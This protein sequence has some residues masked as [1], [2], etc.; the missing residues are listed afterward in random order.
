MP[1]S[2]S[3]VLNTQILISSGSKSYLK[4]RNHGG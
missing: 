4:S 3:F 1:I 2:M